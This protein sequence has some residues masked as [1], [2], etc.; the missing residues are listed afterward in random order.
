MSDEKKQTWEMT[1]DEIFVDWSSRHSFGSK[2][3]LTLSE[4]REVHKRWMRLGKEASAG[5]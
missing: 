3:E 5:F 1:Y 2:G 4:A